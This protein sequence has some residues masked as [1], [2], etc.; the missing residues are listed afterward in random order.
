MLCFV[1]VVSS[2]STCFEPGNLFDGLLFRIVGLITKD[3][4]CKFWGLFLHMEILVFVTVIRNLFFI[5][6]WTCHV[7]K[8]L[9]VFLLLM[10]FTTFWREWM[11]DVSFRRIKPEMFQ[12]S[13]GEQ[14]VSETFETSL[15]KGF[16]RTK[17]QKE[18][19]DSVSRLQRICV[20][21]RCN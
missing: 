20:V 11:A 8:M 21:V 4:T 14:R 16:V 7:I 18:A 12:M 1:N 19:L 17:R 9:G 5:L 10:V 3:Q 2:F 13:P 15:S 6:V